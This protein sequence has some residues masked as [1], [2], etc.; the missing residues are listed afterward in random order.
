VVDINFL[1]WGNAQWKM[2][3]LLQHL[4]LYNRVDFILCLFVEF[5][6]PLMIFKNCFL[7]LGKLNNLERLDCRDNQLTSVPILTS[8]QSLKVCG[9]YFSDLFSTC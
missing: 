6:T 2:N 5:L 4:N 1:Y 3:A 9:A 7:D 8:C